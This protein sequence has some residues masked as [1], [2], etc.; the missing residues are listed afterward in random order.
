MIVVAKILVLLV[1]IGIIVFFLFL[2]IKKNKKMR[3]MEIILLI[4]C[5]I[6]II[7][8]II[9]LIEIAVKADNFP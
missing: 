8:V 6:I 9:S 3:P 1:C 4:G 7:R 5:L 2:G